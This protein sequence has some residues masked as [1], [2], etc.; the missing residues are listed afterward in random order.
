[1]PDIEAINGTAA[2]DIE[3][4]NGTAKADIEAVNGL[5]FA[6]GATETQWAFGMNSSGSSS[7]WHFGYAA[8]SDLSSWTMIQAISDGGA[9]GTVSDETIRI[10]YGH[11][12]GP[13]DAAMWVACANTGNPELRWSS[14]ADFTSATWDVDDIDLKMR[15]IK[16]SAYSGGGVWIAVGHMSGSKKWVYR[17]TDGSNWSNVDVSGAT[18][19]ST[20]TCYGLA[21]SGDGKFMFFQTSRCYYS[22]DGG[23]TWDKIASYSGGA[24]ADVAYTTVDGVGVWFVL[25]GTGSVGDVHSVLASEI[26]TEYSGG[27]AS[28]TWRSS[29]IQDGNGDTITTYANS[30]RCSA[31]AGVAVVINTSNSFCFQLSTSA[32]PAV[33]GTKTSTSGNG[34]AQCI[35][36]SPSGTWLVG[37][38]GDGDGGQIYKSTD[39]TATHNGG[40]W[41]LAADD[42]VA[43]THSKHIED[44]APNVVLPF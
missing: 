44:I 7:H 17:S 34:Y 32:A 31:A 21:T 25:E 8:A 9:A 13:S 37:R 15:N 41:T 43:D 27:G 28:A 6:A 20:Q 5:N 42:L 24:V 2:A 3:A 40:G 16:W 19:M 1:M 18:S 26:D 10:C 38:Q 35:S 22:D 11:A 23:Q 14:S 33:V 12:G 4:V 30:S 39:I 29:D 36:A